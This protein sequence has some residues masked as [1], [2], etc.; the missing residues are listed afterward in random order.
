MHAYTN[1]FLFIRNSYL[2][3]SP[4]ILFSK[5][6]SLNYSLFFRIL[7]THIKLFFGG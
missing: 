7:I 5:S 3:K 2:N 6:H 4:I 1:Y